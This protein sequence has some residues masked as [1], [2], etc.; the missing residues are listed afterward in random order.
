MNLFK[1]ISTFIITIFS[2][3]AVTVAQVPLYTYPADDGT[4]SYYVTGGN[5]VKIFVEEK[6]DPTKT[7]IIFSSGFTTSSKSWNPQWFDPEI[8]ENFHIVRYDY[9]G[10][11]NSDKPNTNMIPNSIVLNDEK[12]NRY[13]GDP[14]SNPYSYDLKATDLFAIINKLSSD[15][16]FKNKKIVLVGWSIGTP[17]SLNFMKNYPDIKIDGFISVAGFVNNTREISDKTFTLFQKIMDPEN[18]N[19]IASGLDEFIKLFS[20]KPFSYELY[21]FFMGTSIM[22]PFEYRISVA[23]QVSFTEFY[24]NLTIPTL[25]I[26]GEKDS[27]VNME[28]SLYFA[29]L[30]QNSESIIYKDIGHCPLWENIKEFNKDIINFVSKI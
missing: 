11:G 29:S 17:I 12:F 23:V 4:K 19:N 10:I 7:T 20:F 2:V 3:S 25:H 14:N 27:L 9:R 28:H 5:E 8:Y 16:D 1:L 24:S 26:I 18:L 21:S 22:A 15:Y 13:L 6:G 30:G